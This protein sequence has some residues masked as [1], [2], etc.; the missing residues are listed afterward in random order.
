M[1]KLSHAIWPKQVAIVPSMKALNTKTIHERTELIVIP[2]GQVGIAVP[3][4][5]NRNPIIPKRATRLPIQ[6]AISKTQ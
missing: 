5:F 1:L 2:Y 6:E 4:Y 3:S